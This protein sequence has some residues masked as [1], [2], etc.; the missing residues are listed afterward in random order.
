[1]GTLWAYYNE[2]T[3]RVRSAKGALGQYKWGPKNTVFNH[4]KRCACITHHQRT[5]KTA[6]S[7]VGVNARLFEPA[8]IAKAR[9][10]KLDGADSWKYLD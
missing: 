10:R 3:V 9:V 4:C 8:V 6:T 5:L 2:S 1:Y 7:T